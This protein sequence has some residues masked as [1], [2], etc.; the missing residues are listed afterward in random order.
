MGISEVLRQYNGVYDEYVFDYTNKTAK[1]IRRIG[2]NS[3]GGLYILSKELVENLLVPNF[4]F[5]EGTNTIIIPNYSANLLVKYVIKNDYT[6]MFATKVEMH[7]NISQ[8]AE[9]I[10]SEVGKNITTAKGELEESISTVSQRAEQ[11]S[12]EVRK[13][14]GNNEIISKINQSSEQIAIQA[15]KVNLTGYVTA[16]DLSN[17]GSTTINGANVKTGTISSDRLDTTTIHSSAGTIGGFNITNNALSSNNAGFTSNELVAFWAGTSANDMY[18]GHHPFEATWN[19]AV[20]A[21]NGVYTWM[22]NHHVP[23]ISTLAD[24]FD[25]VGVEV[26]RIFRNQDTYTFTFAVA[27]SGTWSI[28]MSP[29]SDKRLKDNIKNTDIKGLD[30]INQIQFRQFDWNDEYKKLGFVNF[31][32]HEDFGVVADELEKINQKFVTENKQEDGQTIKTVN[33]EELI[34][35]NAKSVQELAEENRIFREQL[36]EQK[37]QMDLILKRMEE[38]NE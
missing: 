24:N 27:N 4:A 11:I 17:S 38:N 34:Y 26:Q 18:A 8:T 1:V 14:V 31:E 35:Y 23:V 29:P 7:S 5:M 16:T 28:Q 25:G 21:L 2:V 36:Q 3:N 32:R 12:Q 37:A 22:N 13:K 6:N 15:N 33:R 20:Y 10:K 30:V 19:G 9:E